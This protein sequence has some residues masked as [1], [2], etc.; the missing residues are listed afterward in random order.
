M[1]SRDTVSAAFDAAGPAGE[2]ADRD[3]VARASRAG[4]PSPAGRPSQAGRPSATTTT[5]APTT[6][7]VSTAGI[8]SL[9]TAAPADGH[10]LTERRGGPVPPPTI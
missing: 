5:S 8:E 6:T 7:T 1:D 4:G 2:P 10:A 9:T 3:G